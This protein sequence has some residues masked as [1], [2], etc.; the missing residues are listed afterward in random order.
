[1]R[2]I[3]PS[4]RARSP[5]FS[6]SFGGSRGDVEGSR[7][8]R[9]S[10][11][12]DLEPLCRHAKDLHM[13]A[14]PARTM[15]GRG[16][17]TAVFGCPVGFVRF[18]SGERCSASRRWLSVSLGSGQ[19]GMKLTD[20]SPPRL[21]RPT[22]GTAGLDVS[23]NPNGEATARGCSWSRAVSCDLDER[24]RLPRNRDRHLDHHVPSTMARPPPTRRTGRA[25]L[26]LDPR[27]APTWR[28]V[29]GEIRVRS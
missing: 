17:V 20:A 19:R 23:A 2:L 13:A 14:A 26:V 11:T 3:R 7:H 22:S 5:R 24:Q 27:G 8:V 12:P 1:M 9:S 4:T 10:C 16:W 29:R 18:S 25:V 21:N 6:S 28:S 15:P